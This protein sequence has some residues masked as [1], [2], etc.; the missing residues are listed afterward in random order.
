MIKKKENAIKKKNLGV[1]AMEGV[2]PLKHHPWQINRGVK[3]KTPHS[4]NSLLPYLQAA[5]LI[6]G[7]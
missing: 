5:E 2:I 1:P 4:G 3:K 7:V 6:Y